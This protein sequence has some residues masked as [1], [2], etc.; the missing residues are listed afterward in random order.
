MLVNAAPV[1]IR[2][3]ASIWLRPPRLVLLGSV[4]RTVPWFIRA[5]RVGLLRGAKLVVTNQ[6]NPP[7][8]QL[9]H[10]DRVVVYARAQAARF[11]EKG[12]FLALPAD[13]DFEAAC[14]SGES[15][16]YVFSGGGAGRD[17]PTL[18]RAVDGTDIRLELVVFDQR[19]L[20]D[21]PPN[22]VVSG[23]LSQTDFLVRMAGASV[24]VVTVAERDSP[25]GQTTLVQALAL[26]KPVVATRSSGIA[27]YVDDGQ[28]GLLVEPGDIAG[29]REAIRRLL[30]DDE[31]RA[32]CA[33]RSA[34]RGS[35][36]S[37]SHFADGLAD[38]CFAVLGS[39]A[40]DQS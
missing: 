24:V 31:L 27:D 9:E 33:A 16:D 11:G 20:G 14:R 40:T 35:R 32:G 34:E 13:G 22:V 26:G 8:G 38:V 6:L 19:T 29:L 39:S 25:H 1:F 4:E 28:E 36:L 3:L 7:H 23:P 12:A 18:L 30:A 10:I 37:Y 5:R 21:R 17:F 2:A 15:G